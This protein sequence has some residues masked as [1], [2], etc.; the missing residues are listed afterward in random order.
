[1]R[2]GLERD[3]LNLKIVWL[4]GCWEEGN[5]HSQ[6]AAGVIANRACIEIGDVIRVAWERPSC[7]ARPFDENP[8]L[9]AQAREKEILSRNG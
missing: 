2:S 4:N 7:Q 3:R 8:I 5:N 1:M 6:T 9:E